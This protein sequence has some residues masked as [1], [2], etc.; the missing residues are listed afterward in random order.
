MI[1]IS[2]GESSAIK[3]RN[4]RKIYAW[5]HSVARQ[6][7]FEVDHFL[8]YLISDQELLQMNREY[9]NHD[10]LTD[11]LTFDYTERKTINAELYI[12]TDRVI[13]NAKIYNTSINNEL[14]RVLVHGLLH[15]IG[16]KDKTKAD[17]ATMRN[18]ENEALSMLNY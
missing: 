15:C 13:E 10:T 1:L 7:S 12:S 2:E 3:L 5:L 16:F 14:H 17:K 18:A 8:V 4:K 6:F 9:L 11:I